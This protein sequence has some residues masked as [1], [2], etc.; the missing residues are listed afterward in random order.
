VVVLDV[1]GSVVGAWGQSENGENALT[2]PVTITLDGQGN[3]HVID[4][5]D[6]DTWESRLVTF[7]LQPPLAR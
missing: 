6:D 1:S 4:V 2:H 5:V 7:Q 3:V